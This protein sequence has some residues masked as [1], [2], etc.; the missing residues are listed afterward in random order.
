MKCSAKSK[1]SGQQCQ[2]NAMPNGTCRMH[3]GKSLSGIASP[4]YVNGHS[5]KYLP[6][7]MQEK[8]SEIQKRKDRLSLSEDIDVLDSRIADLFSRLDDGESGTLWKKA[9]AA[10]DRFAAAQVAQDRIEAISALQELRSHLRHGL[11]DI[12]AWNEIKLLW[13]QKT[14]MVESERKRKIENQEMVAV[15]KAMNLITA[16][17]ET[18]KRHVTDPAAITN[19]M[20]DLVRLTRGETA[21]LTEAR[22]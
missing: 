8:L 4:T 17:A 19:I 2:N 10:F 22:Q 20:H 9:Q 16:V 12:A 1:R 6:K 13:K 7:R 5:S 14:R 18:V 21:R 15:D 3:G 11:D